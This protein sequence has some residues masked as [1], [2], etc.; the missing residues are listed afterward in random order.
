LDNDFIWAW[1]PEAL[2]QYLCCNREAAQRES[3]KRFWLF[4]D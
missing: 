1:Y 4:P 2:P 3:C